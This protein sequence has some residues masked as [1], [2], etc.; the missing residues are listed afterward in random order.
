MQ[1]VG[2]GGWSA[3]LNENSRTGM[4]AAVSQGYAAV[5][6]NGGV[7]SEDPRDWAFQDS[8]S[9]DT[10]APSSGARKVDMK[11]FKHYASTSLKDLSLLGK[12]VIRSVYGKAPEYS[13]WN[14][15]SQGGRQ[16]FKI[17]QD[18]PEAF[19]GIVAS[20]PALN[21]AALM[22]TGY[23]CQQYNVQIAELTR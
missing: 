7:S 2:G 12:S 11:V 15:C 8:G 10:S 3:G 19:D 21:W 18:Y 1:A 5:G 4:L 13:Y 16:G 6:T 23:V 9:K 20:A 14:G 17:A 22:V